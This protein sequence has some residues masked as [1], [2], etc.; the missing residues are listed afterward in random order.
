M[1]FINNAQALTLVAAEL[2]KDED[3]L[4]S[5]WS[6]LVANAN[7]FAYNEILDRLGSRGYTKAQVDQW[8]RGPEVQRDLC[9]WHAL[10][11]GGGLEGFDMST[12]NSYDRRDDLDRTY[13][14][15][16]SGNRMDPTAGE[17]GL[18]ASSG[19]QDDGAI[20]TWPDKD[21]PMLGEVTVW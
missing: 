20:F 9:I 5:Y 2:K 6:T 4:P 14:R 12:I 1:S 10:T 15:D 3:D 18:I 7:D 19:P 13:L 16:S 17:P 8:A 11:R 21:D